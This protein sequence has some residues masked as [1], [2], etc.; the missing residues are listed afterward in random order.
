MIKYLR[1]CEESAVQGF[2]VCV[3]GAGAGGIS[4]AV[5]LSRSGQRVLLLDGGDWAE[6]ADVADAYQGLAAKPHPSADE[7]RRQR[8]GG[9]THLWGG[10]CVPYDPLDFVA[11][12]HV[13]HSG[14]PI[15]HDELERY[16]VEAMH[17]CDA[18]EA[19]FS[20]N[21]LKGRKKPMF[22]DLGG[23]APD[24]REG[25]ERYSL[26]TDFG[27]KFREELEGSPLV[28]VLLRARC[29]GLDVSQDGDRVLAAEVSDGSRRMKI[30]AS[31]IVLC[32]GGIETTRLLLTARRHAPGWSRF[33][34][35]LGRY[36]GC[37]YD[38]IFGSVA[39][40]NDK[41]SFDFE[42][43]VDGVYARRRLQFSGDLLQKHALLN[44]AFRLH[45]PP[46]ADPAHGSGVM[47]T[48]F[49]AKS[50]LSSE[51]QAI[52][53]HGQTASKSRPSVTAHLRNVVTD[54]PSVLR[55]GYD[56]LT[57]R[58]FAARKLPY[59]LVRNRNGTYPFEFNSEQVP[60]ASNRIELSDANDL[61]GMPRVNIHWQ[62]TPDDVRSGVESFLL[63][64][65]LLGST[66]S[67]RLEFDV[68]ELRERVAAAL[69][70]GGH[71]IGSTRMGRSAADSVVDADCRLHG[72]GNLFVASS[73]V[74]PTT[75][76]ANPTLMIVA[77]ALRLA[78]HLAR[79]ADQAGRED[80]IA[81]LNSDSSRSTSVLS[82]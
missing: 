36:Y 71:H 51:Y 79:T 67:V 45:F 40:R 57:K 26:P 62:L 52:L 31:R 54:S 65:R 72:V 44:S 37:H 34:A 75:S 43:T 30:R 48:I 13:P 24:P 58:K 27:R 38:L 8:F 53:N 22:A 63:L 77:L 59:T 73:S 70:V 16:L 76:H 35:S 11:R 4:L 19:D 50:V 81:P 32:G 5:A 82:R 3:I 55:F 41:P 78:D 61:L 66:P 46:Y 6:S 2:P 60:S 12:T 56:W 18:G 47:S 39:F 23:L 9:T 20:V 7:Y 80:S 17:Y 33:D 69:P 28:Q 21:A 15:A 1:E 68:G 10:R 42:K 25:I 64:K 29:T 74:F 14:W 49:L